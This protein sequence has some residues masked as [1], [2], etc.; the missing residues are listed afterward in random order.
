VR[1]RLAALL[2][3]TVALFVP[4]CGGDDASQDA[5][6]AEAILSGVKALKPGE[7]LIKGLRVPRVSG[8]YRLRRGGYVMRFEQ[9][10]PQ[11][12]ERLRVSLESTRGSRRQPYQLVVDTLDRS[13][14]ARVTVSGKL[15]VHV[16]G[17]NPPYT[18]RFSPRRRPAA[19]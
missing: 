1:P 19:R 13:G 9:A 3:A 4:A 18:L 10:E 14:Q 8:P 5:A 6:E 2:V 17:G 11:D 16:Q 15:Y 7:T 12:G